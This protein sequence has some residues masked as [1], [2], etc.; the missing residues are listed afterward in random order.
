MVAVL[1]GLGYLAL[2]SGFYTRDARA[3]DLPGSI[4]GIWA[5]PDC[6][7]GRRVKIINAAGIVDFVP[8]GTGIQLQI[9]SFKQPP[10]A[11]PGG[12]VHTIVVNPNIR[13]EF[14]VELAVDAERLNGSMERC[15]T[16]PPVVQWTYGEAIAGFEAAG[17][18][19]TRCTAESGTA[20][21]RTLFEFVDVT[22]DGSLSQ[23]E[24]ARLMRI[25]GFYAGYFAQ[26]K[27][28]VASEEVLVASTAAGAF[29]SV[30]AAAV[31]ANLDY[32]DDGRLSLSELVQDRGEGAGLPAAATAL[33][34]VTAQVFLQS[35]GAAVPGFLQFIQ[36]LL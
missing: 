29:G 33:Q 23:A 22:G 19:R 24:V 7:S 31:I 27:P 20:C 8:L 5:E 30:A 10:T 34:P 35:I 9:T 15:P 1:L 26:A 2:A 17:R 6:A 4:A 14:A 25:A 28:L 32:D 21:L 16:V 12:V 13:Q 3:Q 11:G 18:A 36:R